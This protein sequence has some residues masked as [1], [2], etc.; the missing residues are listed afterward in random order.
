M[1]LRGLTASARTSRLLGLA[2]ALG[3]GAPLAPPAHAAD[4]PAKATRLTVTRARRQPRPA[5]PGEEV[6]EVRVGE[7]GAELVAQLQERVALAERGLGDARRPFRHG[8]DRAG[9]EHG[10]PP[11]RWTRRSIL[12]HPGSAE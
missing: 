9:L 8:L 2:A 11:V 10:G 1:F 3:C 5:E 7:D 4:V 6:G 12:A